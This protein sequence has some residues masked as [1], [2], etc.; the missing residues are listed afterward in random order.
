M[1]P[2]QLNEL[3]Y[4]MCDQAKLEPEQRADIHEN[5]RPYLFRVAVNARI[6]P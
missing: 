3:L 6:N 1:L 4:A 2:R 5:V